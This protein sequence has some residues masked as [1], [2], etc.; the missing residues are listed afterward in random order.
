MN[1]FM[2]KLTMELAKIRDAGSSKK[3]A[4]VS[5]EM[6]PIYKKLMRESVEK[7]YEKYRPYLEEEEYSHF[8]DDVF[9]VYWSYKME[10]DKV[11][12]PEY[13]EVFRDFGVILMKTIKSYGLTIIG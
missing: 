7:E 13:T 2:D 5:K 6:L 11:E 3:V 12:E 4:A 9:N 8:V 10:L 1:N